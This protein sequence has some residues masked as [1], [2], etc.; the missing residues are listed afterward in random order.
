MWIFFLNNVEHIDCF[1]LMRGV[2]RES[3]L[4]TAPTKT[5]IDIWGDVILMLSIS[6][7]RNPIIFT[8]V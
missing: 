4:W 5:L 7:L 2:L 3:L 1:F 8:N 6:N